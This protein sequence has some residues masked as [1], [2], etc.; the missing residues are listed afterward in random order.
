MWQEPS[1]SDR[2]SDFK[3]SVAMVYLPRGKQFLP[4]NLAGGGERAT[5]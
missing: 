1:G 4:V 5:I 3:Q 2:L